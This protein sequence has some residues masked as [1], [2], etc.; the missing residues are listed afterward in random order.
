MRRVAECDAQSQFEI[1]DGC[2]KV[3]GDSVT[4]TNGGHRPMQ[5]A[6]SSL[7]LRSRFYI[8]RVVNTAAPFETP[9]SLVN[10]SCKC[11]WCA[12]RGVLRVKAPGSGKPHS[13]RNANQGAFPS[14]IPSGEIPISIKPCREIQGFSADKGS[15]ALLGE[16]EDFLV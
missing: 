7:S 4:V 8:N 5:S 1:V 11:K 12:H 6:V 13:P 14:N 10:T 15:I 9:L 16:S 2:Y 3:A